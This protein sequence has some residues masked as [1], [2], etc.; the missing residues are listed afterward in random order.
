MVWHG[1]ITC[2]KN[3]FTPDYKSSKDSDIIRDR[4]NRTVSRT[5]KI[6][7]KGYKVVEMKEC[8]WVKYL[9]NNP[10]INAL[11]EKDP[12]IQKDILRGRQS[13]FGGRTNA[14][15]LYCKATEGQEIF[16][17]DF[18]SLYGFVQKYGEYYIKHPL[19][20]IDSNDTDVTKINGF[21]SC[22]VLA[23][24]RLYHPVLPEKLGGKLL[25]HLCRKCAVEKKNY[26]LHTQ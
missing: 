20:K 6:K 2:N 7:K 23:P 24:E 11:L 16:Y 18:T 21:V 15:K 26:L 13:L 12:L 14:T 3:A 8:D 25:F 22:T 4:F 1:C 17:Y 19:V 10:D 9:K 5:Q